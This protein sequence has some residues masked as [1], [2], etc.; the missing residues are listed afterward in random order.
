MAAASRATMPFS[1]ARLVDFGAEWDEGE[2]SYRDWSWD[3]ASDG[4]ADRECGD[5]SG[6]ELELH[7]C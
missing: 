4:A 3:W 5:G 6:D 7:F 2:R 1:Y